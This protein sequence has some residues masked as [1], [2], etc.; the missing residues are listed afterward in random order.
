M[1]DARLLAV[2]SA[3]E[4][5]LQ[6]A[7]LE[8]LPATS[9]P[10][11]WDCRLRAVVWV[12]RGAPALTTPLP[13]RVLPVTV[14]AVIDYLDTPVGP[15]REVFAA[16]VVRGRLAVHVPFMAVD[17]L[18]SLRGGRENWGLPKVLAA[19]DG[20]VAEGRAT[21]TGDGWSVDV[22]S[23]AAPVPVPFAVAFG[24]VQAAGRA[25]VVLRG[26]GR[27]ALVRVRADGPSLSG[28]LGVGTHAGLVGEGTMRMHP[29]A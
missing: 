16:P 23:S 12:Q 21:A 5:A 18:A 15:Y 3:P 6:P 24:N 28:W 2:P 14:G 10:A 26:R 22:T 13:G 1:T 25:R 9:P 19:F 11:P 29:T 17:S 8:R 27:P 7:V 20:D 4:S